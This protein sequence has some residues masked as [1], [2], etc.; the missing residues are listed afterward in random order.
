M[1]WHVVFV[2][3]CTC[4]YPVQ[5]EEPEASAV[6]GDFWSKHGIARTIETSGEVPSVQESLE[7]IRTS[8]MSLLKSNT[9]KLSSQAVDLLKEI[10]DHEENVQTQ[11]NL[12]DNTQWRINELEKKISENNNR[13]KKEEEEFLKLSSILTEQEAAIEKQIQ[14]CEQHT[15]LT[16]HYNDKLELFHLLNTTALLVARYNT[17][18]ILMRVIKEDARA[19]VKMVN[20]SL[21]VDGNLV[22]PI[23]WYLSFD[24]MWGSFL[25][26]SACLWM[27]VNIWIPRD[28]I[29]YLM[30]WYFFVL[31]MYLF[32]YNLF[33]VFMNC[34][35]VHSNFWMFVFGTYVHFIWYLAY[36]VGY[37]W[38][39]LDVVSIPIRKQMENAVFVLKMFLSHCVSSKVKSLANHCWEEQSKVAPP[40][41]STTPRQTNPAPGGG[42]TN[43]APGGGQT[44]P[45]PGRTP[46]THIYPPPH[47]RT[48][49]FGGGQQNPA[50]VTPQ[51]GSSSSALF[52]QAQAMSAGS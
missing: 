31:V 6:F 41:S 4:F 5:G 15:K 50:R 34:V 1:R 52:A 28:S 3:L 44:N 39:C 38:C 36:D 47:L 48:P 20:T 33:G 19:M 7:D 2:L 16:A 26:W 29:V 46:T 11:L 23:P 37:K 42:Q 51:T 17:S 32:G 49:H 10:K 30:G 22:A 35:V 21:N 9:R 43:P 14:Q 40:A 13:L 18:E 12:I 27:F 45:A 25:W 24:S 8:L